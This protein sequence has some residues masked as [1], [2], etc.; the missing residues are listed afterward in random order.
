MTQTERFLQFLR[1]R[2]E[3]NIRDTEVLVRI[4]NEDEL[5]ITT[6][7]PIAPASDGGYDHRLKN[8]DLLNRG[9]QAQ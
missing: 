7:W 1:T 3:S 2:T 5:V 8:F 4:E 9:K 6:R